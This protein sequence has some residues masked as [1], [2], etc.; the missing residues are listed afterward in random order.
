MLLYLSWTIYKE[1]AVQETL[2]ELTVSQTSRDLDTLEKVAQEKLAK[3]GGSEA[4]TYGRGCQT[5]SSAR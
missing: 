4:T 1:H 3:L 5:V 2:V